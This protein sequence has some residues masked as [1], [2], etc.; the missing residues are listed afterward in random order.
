MKRFWP[1][2]LIENCPITALSQA[3]FR[4]GKCALSVSKLNV[5]APS[6]N[7]RRV[8]DHP[9]GSPI[10]QVCRNGNAIY[11]KRH[12]IRYDIDFD[13]RAIGQCILQQKVNSATCLL[14]F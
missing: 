11:L 9:A 7:D 1:D 5:A 6:R 2:G 8:L 12:V 10:V 13:P 14:S 3:A 4:V